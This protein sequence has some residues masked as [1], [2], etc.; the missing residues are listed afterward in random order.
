MSYLVRLLAVLSVSA[1]L[2][3]CGGTVPA[4]ACTPGQSP[5]GSMGCEPQSGTIAPSDL[6]QIW[7]PGL[8]PYS[9]R[10]ITY[11][12]FGASFPSITTIT[13]G[14]HSFPAAHTLQF[15][16]ST[17]SNPSPGNVTVTITSAVANMTIGTTGII[18][19]TNG[20]ILYSNAGVL[21]QLAV[22]TNVAAALGNT[23]NASGGL[24]GFSG[25]LGTP[26][27]GVL[28][29]ATGLPVA[30]GLA[31][32]G[33]GVAAAL[34]ANVTG[35]GGIALATSPTF[36]TPALGTPASGVLTHAT[37]LPVSTGLTGLGT[38]V[39]TA[40]AANV[41]GSGGIVLATSPTLVTPALGTPS[42]AVLTN[43]TGLPGATGIS[44][45]IPGTFGGTGVNNGAKTITLGGS[46]T[47]TGAAT[48][49]LAFGTA[50][51]TYTYP[52]A[53][54]TLAELGL[55]QGWGAAQTFPNGDIIL[56]GSGAG[57]T[58]FSTAQASGSNNTITLPASTVNMAY[59]SSGWTAGNCLQAAD[60]LGGISTASAA[61]G[62]GGGS[63]LS[64]TD[65]FG[66]VIAPTNFLTVQ[67]FA[68][69]GTTPT[70]TLTPVTGSRTVT[71][72]GGNCGTIT[73]N[74]NLLC[75]S[76]MGN[77]VVLNGTNLPFTIGA[78]SSTLMPQYAQ[79]T[80]TNNNATSATIT[81]TPAING[82]PE[83][84]SGPFTVV[85]PGLQNSTAASLGLTSNGT[86]LQN[87]FGLPPGVLFSTLADQTVTGG[88]I[89]TPFAIGTVSSGTTTIDC[90][91][92]DTQTL[93]NN[94]AFT[95]AMGTNKGRCMLEIL[96]GASAGAITPSGF[97]VGSNTGDYALNSIPTTNAAV[98]D[99]DL[100]RIGSLARYFTYSYQTGGAGSFA[101]IGTPVA[102]NAT[103]TGTSA[104]YNSTGAQIEFVGV[105]YSNSSGGVPAI[106]DSLAN[107]WTPYTAY[108]NGGAVVRIWSCGLQGSACSVG[109][110]QTFTVTGSAT[111]LFSA[112][113]Q[114][115]SAPS[116]Y[117][118]DGSPV[119]NNTGVAPTV[120]PGSITPAG[121]GDLFV[122]AAVNF[123]FGVTGTISSGFTINP[124][125][126]ANCNTCNAGF[127]MAYEILSGSSA[128]NPTFTFATGSSTSP[129]TMVAI[130]P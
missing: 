47:T 3:G 51:F 95:L 57:G 127:V 7:Q 36:V 29:N 32:L 116:L 98:V 99:V 82:Y 119:G 88:F 23:L 27:S 78:I 61:C 92:G 71:G 5:P 86:T 69:T 120:Q 12:N 11:A 50:A 123:D 30:T 55:A 72:T 128:Q 53:T 58:I 76:D 102:W 130:K 41:T 113:V 33:T 22:G 106:S 42:A 16:G 93:T 46:I 8:F 66:N 65:A 39:A 59:R 75:P 64:V 40:L 54:G 100:T 67:G 9:A 114:A 129:A 2:L 35:S 121:A 122:T 56:T 73:V 79:T 4:Q 107:T 110:T 111:I 24:V 103:Q 34:A 20:D 15:A 108:T 68:I 117:A 118:N 87:T 1:L 81:T 80:I 101:L 52:G 49:T 126:T 70:G 25:A 45:V 10:L 124:A 85:L 62:S 19:A 43:A 125:A 14:V 105:G 104:A 18:G 37:G 97:T 17:V 48:P 44:G 6:I 74:T 26:A 112:G 60:T 13:D 91:N 28:T 38:G 84:G 115:F 96:N 109:G 90:G 63:A 94:G 31:G 21:G 77:I 89:K 83:T